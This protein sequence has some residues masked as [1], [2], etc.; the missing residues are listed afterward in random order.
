MPRHRTAPTCLRPAP[1]IGESSGTA[2]NP[3]AN[4]H[5]TLAY[6]TLTAPFNTTGQPAISLPLAQSSTGLPIG[7]QFV[8]AYGRED[9]LLQLAGQLERAVPWADHR[10][11]LHP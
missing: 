1:L 8:G 3:F 2:E 10:A 9:L 11:P 7:L 4:I 6:A 5:V